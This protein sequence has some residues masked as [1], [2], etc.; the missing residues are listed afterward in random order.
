M[1]GRLSHID[2][3]AW[4]RSIIVILICSIAL[5][6]L[7]A[8]PQSEK[9]SDGIIR[10]KLGYN[11]APDAE[12]NAVHFF[13]DHFRQLLEERSGGRIEVTLY[14]N[15]QLGSEEQMIE[16]VMSGPMMNVS[17][18]AGIGTV[19]PEL[20]AALVPFMFDSYAAG[21]YFF[22]ESEFWLRSQQE[23]RSRTG[24]EL[25]ACVE[26]G[27]FLA[28]TNSKREIREPADFKGL[29]FRAMDDS[30]V[31]LY[32][33]FGAGATPIPWTEL[34]SALQAGVADGQMNPPM[35]IILGSLYEVQKY[36]TMANI[37]YSM[38][39]LVVNGEWMDSLP[40]DLQR[41]VR[42]AADEAKV[43]TREDVENRV[44]ERTDLIA[45]KGVSVYYPTEAEMEKFRSI[46]QQDFIDWL[47]KTLGQEWVDL[48]LK[49]AEEANLHVKGL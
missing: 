36:M 43:L 5:L 21:N 45:S 1:L 3:S 44:Q 38:Q 35:Y 6:P 8:A 16:Q 11:G 17:S 23:F 30:Q 15:S 27:G 39:Y 10:V 33:A 2:R 14:P 18:Y 47:L 40:D 4:Y 7:S 32:R 42:E 19:F 49:S 13:A 34:Y 31:A 37:Q 28:F 25:V 24:M 20:Y 41:A 12:E 29:K 9:A 46:G 22:D 48:A 26:E